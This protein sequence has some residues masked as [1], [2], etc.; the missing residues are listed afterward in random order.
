MQWLYSGAPTWTATAV[1]FNISTSP[2]S[3][4]PSAT[5]SPT[6]ASSL[7]ATAS[8]VYRKLDS[9]QRFLHPLDTLQSNTLL[10]LRRDLPR[11]EDSLEPFWIGLA[12]ASGRRNFYL[13]KL[14]DPRAHILAV[15]IVIVCLLY[16]IEDSGISS[17]VVTD[18]GDVLPMI[19]I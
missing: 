7:S 1:S 18:A 8:S 3:T 2:S 11:L 19:G 16:G 6:P 5:I 4:T 9:D 10:F 12:V 14:G 17:G 15:A 13:S